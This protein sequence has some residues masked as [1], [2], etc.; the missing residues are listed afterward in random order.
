MKTGIELLFLRSMQPE[1]RYSRVF[2]KDESER[3]ALLIRPVNFIVITTNRLLYRLMVLNDGIEM[4]SGIVTATNRPL[5]EL[6]AK[7][8]GG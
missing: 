5:Y 2:V 4:A 8:N 7:R 3:R 6:M 1:P